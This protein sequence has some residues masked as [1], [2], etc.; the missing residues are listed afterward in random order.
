MLQRNC[1]ADLDSKDDYGYFP[2]L[3]A[4]QVPSLAK[5]KLLLGAQTEDDARE[6]GAEKGADPNQV[7]NHGETVLHEA[8]EWAMG[9]DMVQLLVGS[10]A[11]VDIKDIEG[12]TP[13]DIAQ[14]HNN[15]RIAAYLLDIS[16][17]QRTRTRRQPKRLI[18]N[19]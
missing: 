17:K 6:P 11:S 5:V 9:Y 1:G 14:H 3:T 13:L 8:C 19:I 18:E 12:N 10:G 15:E 7:N 16:T 4:V 2:L